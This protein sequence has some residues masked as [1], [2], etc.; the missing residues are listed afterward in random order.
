MNSYSSKR[1]MICDLS[2]D[3][4]PLFFSIVSLGCVGSS[5]STDLLNECENVLDLC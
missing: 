1:E 2:M 4:T 3:A 5:P